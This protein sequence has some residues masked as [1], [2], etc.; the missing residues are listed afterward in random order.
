MKTRLATRLAGWTLITLLVGAPALAVSLEVLMGQTRVVTAGQ[1]YDSATVRN[2]GVL[3]LDGGTISNVVP[4]L[5]LPSVIVDA[6]GRFI[7]NSGYIH[8]FENHGSTELYGGNQSSYS[9]ENH[10]YVKFA[11]GDPG[12][13]GSQLVH[14]DGRVDVYYVPTNRVTLGNLCG[15]HQYLEC[16][17]HL[18]TFT[19]TLAAGSYKYNGRC[20]I[21][22]SS[23]SIWQGSIMIA[24]PTGPRARSCRDGRLTLFM[25]Y[26]LA[27]QGLGLQLHSAAHL[28]VLR[29]HGGGNQLER[30]LRPHLSGAMHHR[31]RQR[32]V[33][34]PRAARQHRQFSTGS[35]C[36]HHPRNQQDVPGVVASLII[37]DAPVCMAQDENFLLILRLF[38]AIHR[39]PRSRPEKVPTI[40]NRPFSNFQR[41]ELFGPARVGGAG[42]A[43]GA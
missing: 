3:I 42:R 20:P 22:R 21:R 27:G 23:I 4:A 11:G 35:V 16:S 18:Y 26:Q 43:G 29:A 10:G 14:N 37:A 39:S 36:R 24:S 7:F 13:G 33:E 6:G 38:A 15:F 41:L 30:G 12:S 34:G 32:G 28:Y 1:V 9:S 19:N 8:Y 17:V 40:G 5:A 31:P 2:G 25:D